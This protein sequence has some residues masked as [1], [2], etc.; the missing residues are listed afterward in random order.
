M[1]HR[2]G[3]VHATAV[4][5]GE[6]GVL[7]R[8][9]S[10]AGKSSLALLLLAEAALRGRFARLVADD[11]VLMVRAGSRLIASPHPAIGGLIELRTQ[12]LARLAF[13]KSCVIRLVVD[14]SAVG[15]CLPRLPA[16]T[17]SEMVRI[18]D[19]ELARLRVEASPGPLACRFIFHKLGT[20]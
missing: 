8:G 13:E 17:A 11:R 19:I 18:H 5:I 16:D 7:I 6:A 1:A 12:P 15:E 14:L 4:V 3:A 20:G 2:L 10:G 9:P